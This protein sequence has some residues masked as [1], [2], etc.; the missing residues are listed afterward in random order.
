MDLHV[1][2]KSVI[3]FIMLAVASSV[4]LG[5]TE[6]LNQPEYVGF[7]SLIC[8]EES[9]LDIDGLAG[10]WQ[11][12]ADKTVE[13]V[14]SKTYVCYRMHWWQDSIKVAE[15]WVSPFLVGDEQL[16][17]IYLHEYDQRWQAPSGVARFKMNQLGKLELAENTLVLSFLDSGWMYQ[18]LHE[19]PDELSSQRIAPPLLLINSSTEQVQAFLEEHIGELEFTEPLHLRRVCE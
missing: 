3:K 4:L 19:N 12:E 14:I 16:V 9:V 18:H 10:T 1:M 8:P 11:F 5:G 7:V 13:L 6:A 17:D 15:G 2:W